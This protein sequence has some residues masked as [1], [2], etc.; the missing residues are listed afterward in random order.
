MDVTMGNTAERRQGLR[1]GNVVYDTRDLSAQQ[2]L[3][4]ISKVI[5]TANEEAH[6]TYENVDASIGP[7]IFDSFDQISENEGVCPR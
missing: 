4:E 2:L 7:W 1:S 3:N 5:L 6:F